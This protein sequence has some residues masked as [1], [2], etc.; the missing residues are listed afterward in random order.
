MLKSIKKGKPLTYTENL[1]MKKLKEMNE[2]I[3]EVSISHL[4]LLE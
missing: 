3:K 1:L 2:R 4:K